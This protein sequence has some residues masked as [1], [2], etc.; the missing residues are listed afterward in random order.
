MV[1]MQFEKIRRDIFTDDSN[2]SGLEYVTWLRF[3]FSLRRNDSR[4][5]LVHNV[6]IQ[7]P[8]GSRDHNQLHFNINIK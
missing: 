6:V 3:R 5:I 7:Q 2:C 4:P 8:L 1:E